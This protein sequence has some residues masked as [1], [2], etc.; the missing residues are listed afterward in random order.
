MATASSLNQITEGSSVNRIFTALRDRFGISAVN[1]RARLQRLLRRKH[2]PLQDHA[3]IV[4]RLARIAYSDWPETHQQNYTLDDFTQSLNDI[5]LYHQ[6]NGRG[7][8]T[9]EV[10]LQEREAYPQAER[11]YRATQNSQQVT[12]EPNHLDEAA[13]TSIPLSRSRSKLHDDHAEMGDGGPSPHQ[14]QRFCTKIFKA[15]H[16]MLEMRQSGTPP[17]VLPTSQE[18]TKLLQTAETPRA[19]KGKTTGWAPPGVCM[20]YAVY[21]AVSKSPPKRNNGVGTAGLPYGLRGIPPASG[22]HPVKPADQI[23]DWNRSHCLS[24]TASASCRKQSWLARS[25]R[26]SEGDLC[27]ENLTPRG[28]TNHTPNRHLPAWSRLSMLGK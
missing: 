16:P 26:T 19:G 3:T 28:S 11:L 4:K 24:P 9:I 8:T 12:T 1:A 18:T 17:L 23:G 10:A 15:T 13:T 22:K 6:L 27:Q 5:G 21:P 7:V 14:A 20:D 2:T 25:I